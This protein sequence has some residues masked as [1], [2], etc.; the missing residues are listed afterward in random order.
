M[1]AQQGDQRLGLAA[2]H[3][4]QEGLVADHQGEAREQG[5]QGGPAPELAGGVVG[6]G[7]PE[8]RGLPGAGRG[9]GKGLGKGPV[10]VQG[11]HPRPVGAAPAAEGALVVGKSRRRQQALAGRRRVA[12][13]PGEQLGGA[14]AGQHPGGRQAMELGQAAAQ[15]LPVAVGV[16]PQ[17]RAGHRPHQ[18]QPQRQGRPEGHQRG[19]GI[20]QGA[21]PPP[22][23]P[24][25]RG[26][27]AAVALGGIGSGHRRTLGRRQG[28]NRGSPARCRR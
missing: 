5:L 19:T 10:P 12:G 11:Q 18:G 9:L 6:V 8:H 14:V 17:R 20:E 28:H 16:G 24:R 27:I 4:R 2:R 3:Q 22:Q 21:G 1:L 23:L 15:V 13:G 7:D 25:R 26:Q